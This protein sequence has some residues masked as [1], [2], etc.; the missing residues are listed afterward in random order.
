MNIHLGLQNGDIPNLSFLLNFFKL[1]FFY[2]I[3]Y[4]FL[5]ANMRKMLYCELYLNYF[6]V[7]SKPVYHR[8]SAYT[9]EA[10]V[11]ASTTI[12]PLSLSLFVSLSVSFL[13]VCSWAFP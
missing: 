12:S 3:D 9:E 2:K 11:H 7:I 13:F 6:T 5:R 10:K 1:Q 8:C 4:Y